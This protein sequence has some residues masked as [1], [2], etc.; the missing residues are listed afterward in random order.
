MF[1][2]K[3]FQG[4]HKSDLFFV[5][6]FVQFIGF[7]VFY[8]RDIVLFR[9]YSII[10]EGGRR[11]ALGESLYEDFGVPNGPIQY[12]IVEIWFKIF[13][14]GWSELQKLQLLLNSVFSASIIIL[15]CR[16]GF[17]SGKIYFACLFSLLCNFWCILGITALLLFSAFCMSL[18]GRNII[19]SAVSGCLA[20]CSILTKQDIGTLLFLLTL[21]FV[22]LDKSSW[23]FAGYKGLYHSFAFG[24]S[25]LGFG[26]LIVFIP[27]RA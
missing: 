17:N 5:W 25:T 14:I 6:I 10:F 1:Q 27:T 19:L 9:D 20:A 13:G 23:K 11:L 2:R 15:F 16:M 3:I 8:S 4:N 26:A 24:L 22:N 12:I 7:F 18:V 21:I